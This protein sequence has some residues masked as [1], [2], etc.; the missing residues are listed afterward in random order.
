MYKEFNLKGT[1]VMDDFCL[2]ST[3]YKSLVISIKYM[4]LLIRFE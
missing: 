2:N 4:E 1:E 3:Q